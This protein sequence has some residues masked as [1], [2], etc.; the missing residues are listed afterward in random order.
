MV[1]DKAEPRS[2][3][4]QEHSEMSSR[5]SALVEEPLARQM[6]LGSGALA[7]ALGLARSRLA[8]GDAQTALRMFASLVIADPEQVD[9]HLGMAQAAVAIGQ[10]EFALQ[11][12][13]SAIGLAPQDPAGFLLSAQAC[14]LLEEPGLAREDLEAALERANVS[15]TGHRGAE[16]GKLARRLLVALDAGD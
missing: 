2:E 13:S 7:P 12:A 5:F 15:G 1:Q 6:G 16:L 14:L 10:G 4:G 8:S 3:A 9:H 11:A